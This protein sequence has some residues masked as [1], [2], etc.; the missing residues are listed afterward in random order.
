MALEVHQGQRPV[1][2]VGR[3]TGLRGRSRWR[4]LDE[5]G[6]SRCRRGG[7]VLDLRR[8]RRSNRRRG[9]V[10]VIAAAGEQQ[11][12]GRER[13][14]GKRAGRHPRSR[15]SARPEP[16][17]GGGGEGGEGQDDADCENQCSHLGPPCGAGAGRSPRVSGV[18]DRYVPERRTVPLAHARELHAATESR[19]GRGGERGRYASGAASRSAPSRPSPVRS[20]SA[21]SWASGGTT[22]LPTVERSMPQSADVQCCMRLEIA[23]RLLRR[24][25]IAPHTLGKPTEHRVTCTSNGSR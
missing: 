24:S 3:A 19:G 22:S 20:I 7:G 23:P 12:A 25:A 8:R 13:R 1:V 6:R 10:I 9:L 11:E 21:S 17:E 4:R 15:A 5:V 18:A 14:Q 2:G 16:G